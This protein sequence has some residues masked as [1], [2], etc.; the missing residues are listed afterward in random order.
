MSKIKS[1]H[2]GLGL[3]LL[4][5]KT[6]MQSN[7]RRGST[8]EVWFEKD[9]KGNEHPIGLKAISG[10][11]GRIVAVPWAN[12]KGLEI[13]PEEFDPIIEAAKLKKKKQQVE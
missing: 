11:N 2:L 7:P 4:G 1:A 6:S 13:L 8:V 10:I 5:S 12:I 3:D 9:S